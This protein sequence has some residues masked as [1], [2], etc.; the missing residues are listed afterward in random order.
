MSILMS[1]L[2]W[3]WHHVL[4]AFIFAVLVALYFES[5]RGKSFVRRLFSVCTDTYKKIA[6]DRKL[7]KQEVDC[8]IKSNCDK[9]P[10]GFV[11]ST[12]SQ[13]F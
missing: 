3:L 5:R 8:A 11:T 6:S 2:S 4:E 12:P 1:F 13:K 9:V 10:K 7:L